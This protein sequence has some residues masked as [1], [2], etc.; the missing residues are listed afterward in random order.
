MQVV[1][2]VAGT[3]PGSFNINVR[4]AGATTSLL[5]FSDDITPPPAVPADAATSGLG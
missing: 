3:T 1:G 2:S 4:N 5:T